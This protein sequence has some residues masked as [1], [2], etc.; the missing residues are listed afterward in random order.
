M[1]M[2]NEQ[3]TA[4]P[5]LGLDSQV[6]TGVETY[7]IQRRTATLW[8]SA[9]LCG[10][11]LAALDA[12]HGWSAG[13]LGLWF[14]GAGFLYDGLWYLTLAS[15]VAFGL[16]IFGWI[17]VG[18]FVF[19]VTVWLGSAALAGLLA[20]QNTW[21]P[22]GWV[23][24]L[25]AVVS[26]AGAWLIGRLRTP[27]R[28]EVAQELQAHL[29]TIPYKPPSS[30]FAPARELT[31][32]DLAC[33]RYMFDRALQPLDEFTGFT[34]IDQ[35][36]E[37]AWRYQLVTMNYAFAAL[38][39][40]SLHAFRGYLHEA[41]ANSVRKMLDRRV[42]HYWRIE[43]FLGNL[44]ISA[45]PIKSENVMYSGWWALALGAYERATGDQQFSAPNA[46]TLRESR[47]RSYAYDYPKIVDLMAKQFDERDLC[48]FP[49]EPNW[50]FT[51]CNLYAMAGSLVYDREHGTNLGRD[52][53]NAFTKTLE[54]EFTSSDGRSV[55]IASRRTGLRISATGA[56]APASTSWL[57]NTVNPRVAQS[58]WA[59]ARHAMAE[60]A[61]GRLEDFELST[62]ASVDPGNYRPSKTF[63]WAT[64]MLSAIELGDREMYELASAR[65]DQNGY[66]DMDGVRTYSGSAYANHTAHLARFTEPGTWHRFAWGAVNPATRNGPYLDSLDYPSVL[67][68]HATNDGTAL[69]LVVVPGTGPVS[70]TLGFGGLA[71]NRSYRLV[72]AS[73]DTDVDTDAHGRASAEILLQGRLALALTPNS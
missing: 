72:G 48:F 2:P 61:G 62:A 39:A 30:S 35:F 7:R 68:A 33:A 47:R 67:V 9:G 41:Q 11:L 19:P 24:P 58:Y 14:P 46:L 69:R 52:R 36:R 16:S 4:D 26:V 43:N 6:G 37:S 18:G 54:R 56:L 28:E 23:V 73:V 49:C 8:F 71:P 15:L 55:L 20:D 45:D 17:I 70:T 38:Q 32:D 21:E 3:L 10:T 65:L 31:D 66:R 53:L 59:L 5:G 25:I 44:K 42:W 40:N 27:R 64:S 13:G 60:E 22:S 51:A 57:V 1:T 29:A 50:V 12:G 34:T 63:F